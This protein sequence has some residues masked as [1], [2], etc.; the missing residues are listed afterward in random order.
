[1]LLYDCGGGTTDIA[2]VKAGLDPDAVDVL[3]VTVLARSGLR[4]FGGDDITRAVCRVL[5]AKLA[6]RVAEA[7]NRPI[8]LNWPA[9]PGTQPVERLPRY[10]AQQQ[11]LEDLFARFKEA[12][13]RDDLV[14]TNFDVGQ[15]DDAGDQRRDHAFDLWR[16]GEMMK[17]KLEKQDSATFFRI[18]RNLNR[19]SAAL[20]KGLSDVQT[21]QLV[22]QLEKLTIHRWEIDALVEAQVLK[23]IRN[24]NN[25]IRDKLL[26]GRADD[27]EEEVHWVVASG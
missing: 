19:L 26:T 8:K 21:Q 20:L 16:W 4:G 6:L 23:S 24:C 10:A 18:D 11:A 13:P 15:M 22:A 1:M 17:A 25:L 2:L 7:R 27:S 14:P 12:D 9:A 5:K 3:R